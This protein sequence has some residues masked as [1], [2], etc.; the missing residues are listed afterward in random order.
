MIGSDCDYFVGYYTSTAASMIGTLV[1]KEGTVDCT[2]PASNTSSFSLSFPANI[3]NSAFLVVVEV[4]DNGTKNVSSITALTPVITVG[5]T[6][7][8]PANPPA[9]AA[10]NFGANSNVIINNPVGA[11]RPTISVQLSAALG[12]GVVVLVRVMETNPLLD[13]AWT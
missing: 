6:T 10:P 2:T 7:R 5:D 8:F 3:R 4:V 12:A 9:G 11:V 13:A 1:K